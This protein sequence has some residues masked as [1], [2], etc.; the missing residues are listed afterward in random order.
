MTNQKT[1]LLL[2]KLH[3]FSKRT[4]KH[5][6]VTLLKLRYFKKRTVT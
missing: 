1:A 2:P 4:T 6:I 3:T 5:V